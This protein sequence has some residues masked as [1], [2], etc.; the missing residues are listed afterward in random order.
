MS[1]CCSILR[2]IC[3]PRLQMC[4]VY[5][6]KRFCCKRLSSWPVTFV[7]SLVR[8]TSSRCSSRALPGGWEGEVQR[9]EA[10]EERAPQHAGGE[11]SLS[12]GHVRALDRKWCLLLTPSAGVK[13]Q[14][15][16][17]LQ[18]ASSSAL[19]SCPILF[20]QIRASK[21]S[22]L[23]TRLAWHLEQHDHSPL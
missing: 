17:S 4:Q 18:G 11:G 23:E 21:E 13:R 8:I 5:Y 20:L 19:W 9:R 2:I 15:Q 16:G 7:R 1:F 22:S 14:H 12:T 10:E 6:Q 3:A